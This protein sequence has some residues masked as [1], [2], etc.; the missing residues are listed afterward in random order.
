MLG[1]SEESLDDRERHPTSSGRARTS[2]SLTQVAVIET[3][4]ICPGDAW[5]RRK[6]PMRF[7]NASWL[8]EMR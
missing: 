7:D 3:S 8:L 2:G 1:R 5:G 6:L 4:D